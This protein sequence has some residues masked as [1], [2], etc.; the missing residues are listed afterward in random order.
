MLAM[1]GV[2]LAQAQNYASP[3]QVTHRNNDNQGNNDQGNNNQGNNGQ[4]N[5]NGNRDKIAAPEIDPASAIT[6]LTLLAGGL[7]VI[8]GRRSI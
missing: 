7:A 2:G 4:G 3:G 6:A 8:R 1:A 5:N